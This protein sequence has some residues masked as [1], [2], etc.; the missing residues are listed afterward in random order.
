MCVGAAALIAGCCVG[1]LFDG[2]PPLSTPLAS[3]P[4]AWPLL[5][6]ELWQREEEWADRQAA[7]KE[8]AQE[9]ALAAERAAAARAAEEAAAAQQ[10][11]RPCLLLWG[12]SWTSCGCLLPGW[13]CRNAALMGTSSALPGRPPLPRRCSHPPAP[14]PS[15]PFKQVLDAIEER[16]QLLGLS[17][18]TLDLLKSHKVLPG[19]GNCVCVVFV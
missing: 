2:R 19:S 17:A 9:F 11:G 14:L 13:L 16:E 6:A 5:Q 10:V 18:A 1:W 3:T 8:E 4:P 15:P 7:M 12:V